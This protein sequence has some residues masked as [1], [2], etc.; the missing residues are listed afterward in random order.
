MANNDNHPIKNIIIQRPRGQSHS[1]TRLT[2]R[3]YAEIEQA[4]PLSMCLLSSFCFNHTIQA[5][6]TPPLA[7]LFGKSDQLGYWIKTG[8]VTH[9]TYDRIEQAG[10]L[11]SETI[12]AIAFNWFII[13]RITNSTVL[14]CSVFQGSCRTSPTPKI[15]FDKQIHR[16]CKI[17]KLQGNNGVAV[18]TANPNIQ[19]T[20]LHKKFKRATQ[21]NTGLPTLYRFTWSDSSTQ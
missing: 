7:T 11:F 13:V 6:A 18:Y 12:F 21:G 19:Q 14:D 15:L 5:P 8:A 3:N 4:H 10:T 20:L 1:L 17:S 2:K 16:I 9:L